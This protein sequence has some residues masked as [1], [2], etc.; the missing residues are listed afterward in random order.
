M[1]LFAK[2]P[3]DFKKL[4]TEMRFDEASAKYAEFGDF[5]VGRLVDPDA[6]AEAAIADCHPE[7]RQRRR[8]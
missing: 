2:D 3:V 7:E 6:W 8:I 1:T 5:Y 4:V